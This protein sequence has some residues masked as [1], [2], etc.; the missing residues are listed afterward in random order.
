M[1]NNI[2]ELSVHGITIK[3][4]TIE[5]EEYV[6]QLAESLSTDMDS[7]FDQ[8]PKTSITDALVLCAVDYLDKYQKSKQSSANMR[9]QL[10]EYL[11]DA[12]SAK[13]MLEEEKKQVAI[14]NAFGMPVIFE[15]QSCLRASSNKNLAS[16]VS[17]AQY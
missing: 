9:V 14:A 11:A 5:S 2:I 10:K 4:N 8:S 1:A 7:L 3:V 16:P 6:T 12:A 15:M 17:C 13:V